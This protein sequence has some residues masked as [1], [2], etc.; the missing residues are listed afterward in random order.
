MSASL[1][2]VAARACQM[3]RECVDYQ[4]CA[5]EQTTEAVIR[6]DERAAVVEQFRTALLDGLDHLDRDQHRRISP[7]AVADLIERVALEVRGG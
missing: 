3:D 7:G 6:S 2:C 5:V 1:A 4:Q